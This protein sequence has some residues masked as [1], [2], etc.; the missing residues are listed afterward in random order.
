MHSFYIIYSASKDKFYI[1][2][3]DDLFSRLKKHNNHIY[4]GAFTKIASDWTIVLDYKCENKEDAL[5]IEAFVKRMK[6]KVFIY[7]IIENH[8]IIRDILKKR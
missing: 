2:E 5:F 6:S 8:D 7:K 3:T 1:G 4:K